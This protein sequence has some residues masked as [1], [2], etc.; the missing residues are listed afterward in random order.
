M[1]HE[2]TLFKEITALRTKAQD[3]YNKNDTQAV[4]EHLVAAE[5]V[6]NKMGQLMITVEDYPEV[7]S[8]KAIVQSMQTYN[9]VESQITAARRFYN[10]A[11][12]SL[13][14]SVQIFPGNIIAKIAGVSQMPFFEA[15]DEV[16]APVDADKFLR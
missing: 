14:N 7:K 1:E 3:V 11:V 9:E 4:R 5:Q 2:R 8:D 15:E 12:N 16:K 10:S 13:N 6:L